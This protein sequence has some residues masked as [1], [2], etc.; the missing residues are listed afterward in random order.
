MVLFDVDG[1]GANEIVVASGHNPDDGQ[2]VMYHRGD[3][4]TAPWRPQRI[5]NGL[6]GPENLVVLGDG[7]PGIIVAE[8]DFR[9]RRPG[10]RR[11]IRLVRGKSP[12]HPWSPFYRMH[13]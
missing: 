5:I 1:D 9:D 8:L 3:D 6:C 13:P 11:V 12:D 2:V 4:V 7:A 10:R